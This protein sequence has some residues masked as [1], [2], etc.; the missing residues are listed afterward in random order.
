MDSRSFCPLGDAAAW[1][2]LW[3]GLKYFENEF[4]Y[5]IKHK[6]S[7]VGREVGLPAAA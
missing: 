7:P 3:G 2:I 4:E 5:W 6:A 1:P